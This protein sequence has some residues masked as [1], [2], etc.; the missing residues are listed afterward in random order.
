MA[1]KKRIYLDHAATTPV[2]PRVKKAMDSFW[3]EDF[4]N[5]SAI[6]KE[7][8]KIKEALATARAQVAEILSARP[9]EI[10]FTGGG[11]ESDN[12]ALF[13][14]ARHARNASLARRAGPLHI[15]TS[16]IEHHAVLHSCD[17]L[18]KEGFDITEIK[19]DKNGIVD[20]KEL[21]AVLRPETI[22]VSIM[23]A[24]NEIGTVQPI[25]EI[26]KIL[27]KNQAVLH[28][29]AVQSPSYLDLNVLRLGVDMMSL[30]ASKIYGPKGVGVLFKKRG[31]KLDPIIQGGGQEMRMRAGTENVP[32]I[33]GFAKALELAQKDRE[34]ESKRLEKLRDYFI[35]NVL[36]IPDSVLNGS[37]TE[38]LPNNINI[39]F[40]GVEGEA[41]VLY[42]DEK[43]IA[44]STG[45][46]CT[47]DNL[48]PSHVIMAIGRPYKYAHG[49]IRFTLGKSTTKQN[50]DYTLKVLPD[51][52]KKLRGVSA[53]K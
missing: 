45:S 40:R 1:S 34:K 32:G 28:T 35:K 4:G 52:I 8:R 17:Q 5:P 21:R 26:V 16:K 14:Y 9:D 38:R 25:K 42:L 33:I 29:D 3:T 49:S 2:D 46:A 15:I 6:Y 31:I 18:K 20:L 24:N 30:N 11:T 13:G 22:L 44:C 39:S 36:R 53:M 10:I 43:G 41:V 12:L 27:R 51:I 48:E 50:L 7:G 37:D 19:V 23:Y 47:S